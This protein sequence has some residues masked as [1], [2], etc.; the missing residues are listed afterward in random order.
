MV[1]KE[2][3]ASSN[4][5][6]ELLLGIYDHPKQL[7]IAGVKPDLP[8]VAIV[9]S[10]KPTNYG[11]EVTYQLSYDLAKFGLCIVSGLAS[12]I[13]AIAHQAAIDA[14]GLTV[15]VL[16]SGLDQLYPASNRGLARQ[17]IASGGAIISEYPASTPPL[18]HHF[19]ARNRIIAG[20]SLLTIVTE[21]DARSGS[22]ITASLAL[23]QN[24]IVAAV[25]G[26]I[27]S[28]RSS[29]PNNLL[30]SGAIV[31]TSAVDVLTILGLEQSQQTKH[32]PIARS[33]EEQ[34]LID[35]LNSGQTSLEEI[36]EQANISPQQIASTLSLM[37]ISG[38][39]KCIGA[40]N[41]ILTY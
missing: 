29:G 5:F 10:R 3:K 26:S 27:N 36:I 17:I 21:A 20:L 25:P 8:M 6:P 22:L 41:W 37:E 30:K 31:V 7:Y 14:G 1:I 15:A 40:G 9:G 28:A 34:I 11:R 38:K 39:V 35:I 19:P 18:R 23:E 4:S 32:K 16:G 24:R 2:I 33:E 12:G 13:D